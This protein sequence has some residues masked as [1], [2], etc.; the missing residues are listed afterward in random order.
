M[1]TSPRIMKVAVPCP[2]HSPMLGQRASS[3]TVC[4]SMSRIMV[5]QLDVARTGRQPNL[6]PV[7]PLWSVV[8]QFYLSRHSYPFVTLIHPQTIMVHAESGIYAAAVTA[9]GRARKH[10][11]RAQ[12]ASL[13]W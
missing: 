1:Q 4:S 8:V 2:Q 6:E 13:D 5:L 7:R 9:G 12:P 11:M 10:L 3:H